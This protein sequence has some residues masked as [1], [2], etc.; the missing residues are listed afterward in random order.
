MSRCGVAFSYAYDHMH[1]AG[2]DDV[3]T[4]CHTGHRDDISVVAYSN[5]LSMRPLE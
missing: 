3:I 5:V 2:Q 1:R 4:H